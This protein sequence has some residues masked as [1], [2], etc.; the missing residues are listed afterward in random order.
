MTTRLFVYVY[1]VSYEVFILLLFPPKIV[2][3]D[4]C[5]PIKLVNLRFRRVVECFIH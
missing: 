4:L 3:F 1:D 2:K 5:Q